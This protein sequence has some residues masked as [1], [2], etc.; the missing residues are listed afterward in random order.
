MLAWIKVQKIEELRYWIINECY[1]IFFD[2]LPEQ[3]QFY[4]G[5][6]EKSSQDKWSY[7]DTLEKK[8]KVQWKFFAVAQMQ[9][10][11]QRL[12]E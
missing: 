5:T 1:N 9:N 7:I 2:I 3:W 10:M 12:V 6:M 11:L 4:I 8:S